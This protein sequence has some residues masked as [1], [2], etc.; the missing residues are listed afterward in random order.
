HPNGIPVSKRRFMLIYATHGFR[1]VDDGLS[2]IYQLRE[3]GPTGKVIKE[4]RLASTLTGWEPLGD[5]NKNY[6]RQFGHPVAFGVPKGAM[7][8]GKPAPSAN[9]FVVKWRKVARDY[10]PVRKFLPHPSKDPEIEHRTQ[11]VE[12]MQFRLNEAENDIEIIQPA[13]QLRQK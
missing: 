8:G 4:G 1:G 7:I 5:G 2:I 10:D 6:V 12:W 11:A 3:D 9:V 13:G